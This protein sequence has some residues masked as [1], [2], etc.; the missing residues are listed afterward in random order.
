MNHEPSGGKICNGLP[1]LSRPSLLPK[2]T[3]LKGKSLILSLIKV[4]PIKINELH[5]VI[6]YRL[7]FERNR[8]LLGWSMRKST[9]L[10]KWR[11]EIVL[12]VH[13]DCL[14]SCF[15]SL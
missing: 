15:T 13:K 12:E 1:R 10:I 7:G 6:N 5:I 11:A 4:S 9:L 14:K 8:H 2:F 3:K